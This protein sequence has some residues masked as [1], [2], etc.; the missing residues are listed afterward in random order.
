MKIGLIS[1]T[2]DNVVNTLKAVSVFNDR[3]V[4]LV[5]HAGDII[6]PF[7]FWPLE[8]LNMPWR[9]VIGNNCGDAELWKKLVSEKPERLQETQELELDGKSFFVVHKE[10]EAVRTAKKGKY[11]YVICGH[12]HTFLDKQIGKT[13]LINAGSASLGV[14][15]LV[16]YDSALI[17]ILDTKSGE[18]EKISLSEGRELFKLNFQSAN[19]HPNNI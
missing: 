2:H 19:I 8:E 17:S 16:C 5:I 3:E 14:K 10:V 12:V 7:M 18:L 13:R 11:D 4:D 1:D 9:A 6:A 15:N